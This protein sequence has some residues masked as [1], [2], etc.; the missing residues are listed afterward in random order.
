MRSFNLFRRRTDG[1]GHCL[2]R[3]RGAREFPPDFVSGRRTGAKFVPVLLHMR[4]IRK[5]DTVN[6]NGA[7]CPES[8]SAALAP[9]AGSPAA[10]ARNACP[11]TGSDARTDI[12]GPLLAKPE[13][14]NSPQ[15]MAPRRSS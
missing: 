5:S 14:L 1:G 12:A 7:R 2:R 6:P 8:N 3:P 10:N 13:P 15:L 11:A 4:P 9:P